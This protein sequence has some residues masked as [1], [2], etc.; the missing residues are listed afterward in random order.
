MHNFFRHDFG[1]CHVQVTAVQVEI[2]RAV[3]IGH[4]AAHLLV[5]LDLAGIPDA[6][7]L[8]IRPCRKLPE[9]LFQAQPAQHLDSVWRLLDTGPDACKSVRLFV[10]GHIMPDPA[11]GCR[12]GKPANPGA[13]N[14]Y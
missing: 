13:D 2:R 14:R 11:Q 7:H 12:G 5:P 3:I 6:V 1:Q 10:N 9:P 8:C 4:G